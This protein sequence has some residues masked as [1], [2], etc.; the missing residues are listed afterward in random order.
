MGTILGVAKFDNNQRRTLTQIF[1]L[2]TKGAIPISIERY[3]AEWGKIGNR[4]L[5]YLPC[6]SDRFG[7]Y[8]P[9]GVSFAD[10]NKQFES[11][12]DG[13]IVSEYKDEKGNSKKLLF[14]L[15]KNLSDGKGNEIDVLNAVDNIL[16]ARLG[17]VNDEPVI[18]YEIDNKENAIIV[19]ANPDKMI[20]VP[21]FTKNGWHV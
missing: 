7:S 11:R 9:Q 20:C 14:K 15:E 18:Q 4:F 1:D 17:L 6:A 12:Y 16:L 21:V 13:Y 10:A 2:Q 8:A 19:R 5:A 3:A